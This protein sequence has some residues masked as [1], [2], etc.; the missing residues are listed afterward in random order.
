MAHMGCNAAKK[1]GN[2][3]TQLTQTKLCDRTLVHFIPY[4]CYIIYM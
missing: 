2:V 1:P 4:V 3:I